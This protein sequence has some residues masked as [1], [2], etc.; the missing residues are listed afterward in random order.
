MRSSQ[1]EMK[2][3]IVPTWDPRILEMGGILSVDKEMRSGESSPCAARQPVTGGTSSPPRALSE[4][5]TLKN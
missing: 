3:S 1:C 2:A 5:I 4:I